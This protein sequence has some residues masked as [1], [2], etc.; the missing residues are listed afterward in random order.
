MAEA[1]LTNGAFY[2]HFE[3]KEALV[4]GALRAALSNNKK[5]WITR[6]TKVAILKVRSGLI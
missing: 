4:R 3:S 6:L 2:S 5:R 1:G